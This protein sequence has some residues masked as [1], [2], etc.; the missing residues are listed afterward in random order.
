MTHS[1]P[2]LHVQLDAKWHSNYHQLRQWHQEQSNVQLPAASDPVPSTTTLTEAAVRELSA[3][4]PRQQELYR[5]E[6]L[7]ALKVKLLRKLG[8]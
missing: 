3:W 6:K 7:T 8:E 2:C 5:L 4:L 1:L